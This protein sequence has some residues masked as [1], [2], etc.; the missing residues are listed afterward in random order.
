MIIHKLNK[1]KLSIKQL[2]KENPTKRQTLKQSHRYTDIEKNTHTKKET[3][4][5]TDKL[6]HTELESMRGRGVR[7][8][9]D[10]YKKPTIYTK[11]VD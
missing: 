9:V 6:T 4:G 8:K 7:K 5:Q 11:N 2:Q 1:D 3:K 10:L